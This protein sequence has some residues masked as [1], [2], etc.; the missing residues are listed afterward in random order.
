MENVRPG[1]IDKKKG[2]PKARESFLLVYSCGSGKGAWA[3]VVP[4]PQSTEGYFC[5]WL[6]S[7]GN[8][9]FHYNIRTG[10]DFYRVVYSFQNR[11]VI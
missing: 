11:S 10:V 1:E 5:I 8:T 3:A 6:Q 9:F 2:R 4:T 7:Q